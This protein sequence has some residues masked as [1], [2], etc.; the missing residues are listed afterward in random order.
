MKVTDSF[1]H[2][3]LKQD[4]TRR[5]THDAIR[6][7]KE[8]QHGKRQDDHNRGRKDTRGHAQDYHALG[9]N[10]QGQEIQARLAG[11]EGI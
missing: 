10:R 1:G 2:T 5:N 6:N 8:E 11:L 9:K 4:N 3:I 7:Y